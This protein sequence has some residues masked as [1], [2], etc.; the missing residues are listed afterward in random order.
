MS[1]ERSPR[2]CAPARHPEEYR[3]RNAETAVLEYRR[4][5]ACKGDVHHPRGHEGA[6]AQQNLGRAAAF[7]ELADVLREVAEAGP[8][9]PQKTMAEAH[10]SGASTPQRIPSLRAERAVVSRAAHQPA[11]P[12]SLSRALRFFGEVGEQ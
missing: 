9:R 5:R 6:I 12:R 3:G 7:A 1:Q 2:P 11:S 8:Q 10:S 4:E